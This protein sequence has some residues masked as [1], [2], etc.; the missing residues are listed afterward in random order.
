[1][2]PVFVWYIRW[3]LRS[4]VYI[5]APVV[6]AFTDAAL[7][8]RTVSS[9]VPRSY[10]YD[11][12]GAHGL[13]SKLARQYDDFVGQVVYG[14]YDGTILVAGESAALYEHVRTEY[15]DHAA[16]RW[17]VDVDL[18]DGEN[19][20]ETFR[21]TFEGIKRYLARELDDIRAFMLRLRRVRDLLCEISAL[22]KFVWFARAYQFTG[23]DASFDV[24]G[25]DP[26]ESACWKSFPGWFK[27]LHPALYADCLEHHARRLDC[28]YGCIGTRADE[29]VEMLGE[30][31]RLRIG[32]LALGSVGDYQ[33]RVRMVLNRHRDI[34]K[35][36]VSLYLR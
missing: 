2:P 18:Q 32:V 17:D 36:L 22:E 16:E 5:I 30:L 26:F 23:G 11:V 6:M 4:A 33:F 14:C 3:W 25:S 20:T 27:R 12:E 7:I 24:S 13:H 9:T 31:Y 10:P 1:M 21:A 35:M 28:D 15:S 19:L 29:V 8:A 34:V